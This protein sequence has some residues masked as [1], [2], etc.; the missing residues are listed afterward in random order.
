[1]KGVTESMQGEWPC[2]SCC[3]SLIRNMRRFRPSW[4]VSRDLGPARVG[5][6]LV[7]FLRAD[8]PG[9]DVR[10]VSD[11]RD[12]S[13]FRRSLACSQRARASP[14]QDGLGWSPGVSVSTVDTWIGILEVTGLLFLA[15]PFTENFGKRLTKSPKI[16]SATRAWSVTYLGCAA[17]PNLRVHLS[18][19]YL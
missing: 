10:A 12:L 19:A 9:R 15:Q 18:A 11:I 17:R 5:R 13:V 6:D 8:L 16:T 4:G 14:Q 1:M 3:P 2:S 7:S